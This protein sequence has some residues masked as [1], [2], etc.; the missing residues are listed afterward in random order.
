MSLKR[1]KHADSATV[2]MSKKI[3]TSQ[4]GCKA[5]QNCL[6][7]QKTCNTWTASI[8]VYTDLRCNLHYCLNNTSPPPTFP[9][10]EPQATAGS[11]QHSFWEG[12]SAWR[13]AGGL[14]P[15]RP[16][17]LWH[18]FNAGPSVFTL[19]DKRQCAGLGHGDP[20]P[21]LIAQP[22]IPWQD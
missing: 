20:S 21:S 3:K 13:L 2:L 9:T 15:L 17:W 18:L 22:H 16:H 5:F 14:G 4:C 11:D 7:G 12:L 1:Q 10:P 19:P 6:C 8:I